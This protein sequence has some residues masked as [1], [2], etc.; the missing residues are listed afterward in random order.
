MTRSSDASW[1]VQTNV[2]L[3]YRHDT[4]TINSSPISTAAP[5]VRV[6]HKCPAIIKIP[7][8]DPDGDTVHC[9]FASSSEAGFSWNYQEMLVLDQVR[10]LLNTR[11]TFTAGYSPHSASP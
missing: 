1:Y 5:L 7:V 6:N 11:S 4:G 9:R 2:D 8:E 3:A 10:H